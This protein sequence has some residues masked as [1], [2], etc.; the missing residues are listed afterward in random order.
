MAKHPYF[1]RRRADIGAKPPLY[2]S[3]GGVRYGLGLWNANP[4][5]QAVTLELHK[6]GLRIRARLVLLRPL[7]PTWE[8]QYAELREV[9]YIKR[10]GIQFV[11]SDDRVIFWSYHRDSLVQQLMSFGVEMT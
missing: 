7:V 2:T 10:S 11:V 5:L 1:V 6:S 4:L 3:A 8:A 9:L